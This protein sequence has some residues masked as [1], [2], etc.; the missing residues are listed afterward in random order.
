MFEG[1]SNRARG[2]WAALDPTAR[3]LLIDTS[4]FAAGSPPPR[5]LLPVI[6]MSDV[7]VYLTRASRLHQDDVVPF[8][9][10][11]PPHS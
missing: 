2:Y 5:E 9:G 1:E 7:I 3:A 11:I 6:A 4:G 10:E 8:L